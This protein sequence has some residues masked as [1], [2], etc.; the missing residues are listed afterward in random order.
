MDVSLLA[1]NMAVRQLLVPTFLVPF[2]LEPVV[3]ATLTASPSLIGFPWTTGHGPVVRTEAT[4][5]PTSGERP[6]V[7][8]HGP[9]VT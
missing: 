7:H 2:D 4:G 1:M 9:G 6:F 3:F 8:S 5:A